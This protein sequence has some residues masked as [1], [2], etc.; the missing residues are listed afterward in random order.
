[1][2]VQTSRGILMKL[3]C[4]MA[5]VVLTNML[6]M[7]QTPRTGSFPPTSGAML[8]IN[9]SVSTG[10]GS[11]SINQNIYDSQIHEGNVRTVPSGTVTGNCNTTDQG[12]PTDAYVLQGGSWTGCDPNDVFE[13]GQGT[14]TATISGSGFSFAITTQYLENNETTYCNT[15]GTICASPDTG[16]LTVTNNS[17]GAFTGTISLT[18]TSP[19]CGAASDSSILGL[20]AANMTGSSVTLA[21]GTPGTTASPTLIDSSNCG[22]FNQTQTQT[23]SA[24]GTI[25]FQ[26][27]ADLYTMT[28][29]DNAGGETISFLPVPVPQNGNLTPPAGAFNAGS[30][31]PGD[32]CDSYTDLSPVTG[33]PVCSEFQLSCTSGSDCSTSSYKVTTNYTQLDNGTPHFLKADGVACPPPHGFDENI[34]T[35]YAPGDTLKSGGGGNS[36]F[37]STYAS[38]GGSQMFNVS[39]SVYTSVFFPAG[40][41]QN[42]PV[43]NDGGAGKSAIPLVFRAFDAT[44]NALITPLSTNALCFPST[45]CTGSQVPVSV[46]FV[47]PGGCG[48]FAGDTQVNTSTTTSGG[49]GLQFNG[50]TAQFPNTWQINVKSSPNFAGT[51]QVLELT[52]GTSGGVQSVHSTFWKF[53][54]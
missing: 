6:C 37:A 17:S 49:S 11:V 46:Q 41:V 14:G 43:V 2:K 20:A 32:I 36:C 38:T 51:C 45:A 31:F 35:S 1:M 7:A 52:L 3:I 8:N 39:I 48:A 12:F 28:G 54:K 10:D 27:G 34:F 26:A 25:T 18:G 22:G 5:L 50:P 13:T 24:G 42:P 30:L 47:N 44:S 21:L 40:N 4:C 29:A 53:H 23:L 33:N 16:F 9:G 19:L 15:A